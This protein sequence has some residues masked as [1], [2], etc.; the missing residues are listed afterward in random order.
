[1]AEFEAYR[2]RVRTLGRSRSVQ[3]S[4]AGQYAAD[5]VL[6]AQ[7]KEDEACDPAVMDCDEDESHAYSIVTASRVAATQ[8]S[9]TNNQESGVDEGDIVKQYGRFLIV[10]QDGRLFTIDTGSGRGDL[11]LVDRVDLYPSPESDTWYDELLIHGGM[12]VVTG[13]NYGEDA[14]EIN[15]VSIDGEGRLTLKSRYFLESQDYYSE[16]NYASRLVRGQLVLYTPVD[17]SGRGPLSI[18][19]IRRWTEQAGYSDWQPLFDITDI[20]LPIQETLTPLMHVV[21]VCRIEA[22]ERIACK[23]RGVIGPSFREFYVSAANAYLWLASDFAYWGFGRRWPGPC[24]QGVDPY[25]VEPLS[26]AVFQMPFD[27]DTVRAVHTIGRPHDQF[28]FDERAGK[29]LALLERRPAGCYFDDVSPMILESIPLS[30]FGSSPMT[31]RAWDVFRL[32]ATR[33]YSVLN[34]YT[35]NHLVYSGAEPHWRQRRADTPAELVVVPLRKPSNV[36]R[37]SPRHSVDRL[38]VIGDNAVSFG[39]AEA[40]D[41]GVSTIELRTARPY[42]ADT[43]I[44]EGIEESEGRSHAFNSIVSADGSGMFG[45][46]TV[47]RSRAEEDWD[48][49][50]DVQ[51]F[52]MDR[53]LT[54]N[55]VGELAA[56]DDGSQ[57]DYECEV[58]CYDWYGNAR[59]IFTGGRIFALTGTELVEGELKDGVMVEIARLRMTGTPSPGH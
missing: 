45:L 27:L 29:L 14:S 48:A 52:T 6:L 23:A 58:S 12:L 43:R 42:I 50:S 47:Y 49:P 13:F 34:R 31:L 32:P 15:V 19:R 55:V 57:D 46:P 21:S 26:A 35:R 2:Q 39:V 25:G 16:S 33:G 5:G 36:D 54:V 53:G 9:I 22:S 18:P 38:E 40:S 11:R 59:P 1:M 20:Y 30:Y 10:L 28:A 7:A 56:V 44:L 41:L 4:Q 51:F 37:L 8:S 17:F 24:A 3:W